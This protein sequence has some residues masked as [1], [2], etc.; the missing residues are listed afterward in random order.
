MSTVERDRTYYPSI[1]EALSA[2]GRFSS[3]PHRKP[4][5]VAAVREIVAGTGTR[6]PG[7]YITGAGRYV[8]V[9]G[10][11]AKRIARIEQAAIWSAYRANGCHDR[12]SAPDRN[13]PY[14]FIL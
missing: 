11:D 9:L 12:I 4:R 3:F 10:D 13:L 5:A 1:E 6:S 14:E 2:W 7:F 8:G